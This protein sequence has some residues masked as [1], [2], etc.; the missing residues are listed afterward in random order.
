MTEKTLSRQTVF[1]GRLLRLD[2]LEVE[3]P[4]GSTSVREVVLHPDAVC[5]AVLTPQGQMALVRQ[6]R[7]PVEKVMVEL[8]AGKID[9]GESPE[10]AVRR[11]LKEEIGM[12][13]GQV[14]LLA[15][16][17]STPGFCQERMW[18]YLVREAQLARPTGDHGEWLEPMLVDPAEAL[19]M[20]YDGR[21][22]DAKTMVGILMAARHLGL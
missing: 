7:K 19:S 14:Q 12:V 22:E 16:F 21:I 2:R 9:P 10:E 8:P 11:E 3:L 17:Y 15:R 5:A 20:I 1:Q 4:D 18:L 6:Y 13:A